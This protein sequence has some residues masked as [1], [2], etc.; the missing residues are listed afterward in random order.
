MVSYYAT[1]PANPFQFSLNVKCMSGE[2]SFAHYVWSNWIATYFCTKFFHSVTSTQLFSQILQRDR[3]LSWLTVVEVEFFSSM[4]CSF[5]YVR[6]LFQT[7]H[8][9]LFSVF[10]SLFLIYLFLLNAQISSPSTLCTLLE[11][12]S[13][14]YRYVVRQYGFF[15]DPL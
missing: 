1:E 13:F 7:N 10:F 3:G 14:P 11:C 5:V 8:V 15:S 9:C 2:Y 6:I 4:H 12:N